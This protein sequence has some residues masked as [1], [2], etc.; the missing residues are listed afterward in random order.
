[1]QTSVGCFECHFAGLPRISDDEGW[2]EDRARGTWFHT[3]VKS[4]NI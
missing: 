1:M 4:T 3:G 2:P